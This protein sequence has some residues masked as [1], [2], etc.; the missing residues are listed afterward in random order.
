MWF[1]WAPTL[2]GECYKEAVDIL[3]EFVDRLFQW[4]PTLGGECYNNPF[5]SRRYVLNRFQRAP[6]LGG[7]CY[8]I[9]YLITPPFVKGSTRFLT[10]PSD[11]ELN[12]LREPR[13]K[14]NSKANS[15]EVRAK[16][17]CRRQAR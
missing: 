16:Y 14:L 1:Q 8:G 3:D 15:G 11:F 4:A 13:R 10:F 9:V 12:A 2:G 17:V 5:G 7:E 6:T